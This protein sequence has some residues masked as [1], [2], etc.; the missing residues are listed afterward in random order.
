M[1]SPTAPPCRRHRVSLVTIAVLATMIVPVAAV[2]APG[3][4]AAATPTQRNVTAN[5]F[6]WNWPSVAAECTTVLGPD[7][8]AAVQ[9]AP[10]EDSLK[11]SGNPWWQV[12][13]P[14]DGNL[15]SM[16]GTPA[17]F[18][19]MVSTCHNAGVKVYVDA[20]LNHMAAQA[21]SGTSFGGQAY[22]PSTLTYPAYTSV[23]FH[24]YPANCPESNNSID[25]WLNYTDAT[26]C[27]LEGLPDLATET[28]H[29]RTTQAAYLNSLIALGVDG[30]RL[31]SASSI[32]ETDIAAMEAL[33]HPDTLTGTPVYI[34]QEVYPGSAGQDAR[35]NPASFE[36]EGSV[37]SF[38]YSFALT[39]DFENNNIAALNTFSP[40]L[41]SA[42]ASSFV[43]NH[44]TERASSTLHYTNGAQY[45][46]A[47]EFLLAYGY[48]TPQIYSSFTYGS[49]DQGPPADGSGNVTNTVCGQGTWEC[50]EQLP[51]IV[52]MVGWHNLALTNNDPV[53]N[54]TTAGNN[55]VAFSRGSDAWIAINNGASP[56]T[57]TFA[58]GLANG[59]YCDIV[60]HTISGS[61][62]S[63]PAVTV[64]GG[65]A[66]VTIPAVDAIAFDVN[67]LVTSTTPPPPNT[68]LAL[69]ATLTASSAASGYPASNAN[70]NN[71]STYWESSNGAFPQT[72]TAN[73]GAAQSLGSVTLDLPPATAWSTR[74]E[75]LAVLGSTDGSTWTT[76]VPSAGYT[77]NPVTGNTA[78]ISLPPGTMKQY[79]Q[80]QFTANTGWPAGQISEFQIFPGLTSGGTATLSASPTSLSFASTTIGSTSAAQSVTV[81]NTGTVAAV[82]SSVS[83]GPPFAENNTCGS[84][85]TAGASCTVSVTFTPTATGAASGTLSV[86][87]NAPVS[88]ALSGTGTANASTNLALNAPITASSV[89]QTYVAAH[90]DDGNT[91]SYWEGTNGA[92]P[93]T[94][95]VNLG[96]PQ[97]LGSVVIDLPP[98]TSW[99]TRTQTLSVLGSTNNSTWTT[100]AG[101]ATYT[102]NPAAG[103]TV[104]IMLPTGSTDQYVRL[105]FTANSLQNGAQASELAIYGG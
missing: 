23:D 47:D 26:Q 16:M 85:L 15:T 96:T 86:A 19:T 3:P 1:P 39:N 83:A 72:L 28:T 37:T 69:G 50:T 70:D 81:R 17:Q 92:W 12:Y 29:V 102:F 38:D 101:S 73:L 54:W 93:T 58:T 24:T 63:G 14:V 62:C 104:T 41:P 66:T 91:S 59:S 76:L 44:D 78:T 8:Y 71:T 89:Q 53:T 84:S 25:N 90:A 20:V 22:N 35:L 49:T 42:Y 40:L 57:G 60:H 2:S 74:T 100:L 11:A 10:P 18:S 21:G 64:T 6:E 36:P 33:L 7:G 46:L 34:T 82:I 55:V 48:G 80:L 67:D 52:A 99:S 87:G 32:G 13:Q 97:R 103:N 95:T 61:A 56:V 75:T 27:Q 105:S 31:D 77:F 88:V 79:L 9:V 43:T 65:S 94:L 98:S 5:L 30:F 45:T 68:N 51:G 4:I